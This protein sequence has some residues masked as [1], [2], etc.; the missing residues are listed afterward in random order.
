MCSGIRDAANLSWKL[1]RVLRGLSGPKI[2]DTY[3]SERK[4]HLQHAITM[5]VEL[6]KVIC[7]LDPVQADERD[8]RMIAAEAD[9]ARVLPVTALPVLGPGIVADGIDVPTLRGTLLPQFPVHRHGQSVLLDDATGPGALLLIHGTEHTVGTE[10]AAAL[11]AAGVRVMTI[12]VTGDPDLLDQKHC[13]TEWFD[14]HKVVCVLVRPDHYVF[15]AVESYT[16]LGQLADQYLF[17][18]QTDCTEKTVT[19]EFRAAPAA[20]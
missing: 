20:L 13:W 8:K 16:D 5:S 2:L 10:H 3:T 18:L 9:P 12:A 14:Q 17:A 4:T 6:G 15:G 7:V 11:E 1:D 19:D